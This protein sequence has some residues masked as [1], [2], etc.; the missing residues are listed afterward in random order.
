MKGSLGHLLL[1][2]WTSVTVCTHPCHCTMVLD[3][4]EEDE[5]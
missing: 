3:S 4:E 5:K 2:C 1:G